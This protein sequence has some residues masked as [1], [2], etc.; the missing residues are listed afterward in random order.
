MVKKGLNQNFGNIGLSLNGKKKN[1][2]NTS[3][4]EKREIVLDSRHRY[5]LEKFASVL[6]DKNEN[7]LENSLMQVSSSQV[8]LMNSFFSENGI[9]KLLFFWQPKVNNFFFLFFFCNFLCSKR[10]NKK[11]QKI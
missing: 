11:K 10:N 6:E 1:V 5:L 7:Q 8:D 3:S 4:Y 2:E 9:K